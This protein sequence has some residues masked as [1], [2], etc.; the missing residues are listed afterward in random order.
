MLFDQVCNGNSAGAV[1]AHEQTV[2][3]GYVAVF[4]I[5]GSWSLNAY[6]T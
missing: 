2:F 5:L 3:V 1:S 6:V 4:E